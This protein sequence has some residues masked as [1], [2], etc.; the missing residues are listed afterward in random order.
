MPSVRCLPLSSKKKKLKNL[1]TLNKYFLRYK[2]HLLGGIVF[3]FLS[4]YFKIKIP[5][6]VKVALNSI[7]EL[8]QD[9]K[10]TGGGGDFSELFG[11]QVI[12]YSLYVIGFAVVMGFFMFL[13][14]QTIIVMSRLI[15]YDLRKD[16]FA[17][18]E[19]LDTA[20]YKS[21]KTGDLMSRVAE[22]VGKVRMYLGPALLYG[23]NLV[24]LVVL[25]VYAMLKV[26][27]ELTIYT[28]IPLP[29]LSISIYYVSR[30]I[31][32]RS[33]EIQKQLSVLTA[34]SQEVYSGIRV[35]KSYRVEDR[36]RDRFTEVSEDFKVKSMALAKV[37]AF[38]FPLMILIIS[39]S[40][41]LTIYISGRLVGE[42]QLLP[43]TIVEFIIYVNYLTWP[44]TS[45]G[46]IASIIQQAEASSKR[47]NAILE[48]EPTIMN[49]SDQPISL[50][51]RIEFKNVTFVYPD[52]GVKALDNVSFVL[53]PGHKMAVMGRTASGKSTICELITRMYDVTSGE[54]LVDGIPIAQIELD[55]LR[56]QIG[57]VPQDG[58]L[59]SDTIEKNIA[60]GVP[61]ATK[62]MIE[63]TAKGSD[64]HADILQFTDGYNTMVGERGV[65]LSGGQKQRISIARALIKNPDLVLLDDC[66]SAVD[67]KTEKTILGYLSEE[68]AGKT[69]II[70]TH[71]ILHYISFDTIMVIDQGKI[72]EYGSP[73][74]LLSRKG[75]YYE[76]VENQKY[77]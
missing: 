30:L 62:E 65:T 48:T 5:Q 58:F 54:I 60:F 16:I 67:T 47:I 73:S 28:L 19:K 40:T 45:I 25:V 22:D 11:G 15:E 26:N 49:T 35:V 74:D 18:Y 31:S 46:W 2:W 10:D 9:Q 63:A 12:K 68:L 34:N 33:E 76:M 14:R 13:M 77:D 57:Y 38:F 8:V 23:I 17:H 29:F 3:V 51:G 55:S 20:F 37:N 69:T 71:R 64:V 42:G 27:V 24:G 4:N 50:E 44:F 39:L 75:Q 59:F 6:T 56:S 61:E 36:F 72:V 43:G 32:K 70:V 66:L 1:L 52:T 53:E 21:N 7:F 41:L